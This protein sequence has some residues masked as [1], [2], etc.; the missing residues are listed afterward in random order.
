MQIVMEMGKYYVVIDLWTDFL[1]LIW[2]T[3][4][5]IHKLSFDKL[6]QVK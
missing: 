1:Q 2:K 6:F 5:K 3:S 4:S